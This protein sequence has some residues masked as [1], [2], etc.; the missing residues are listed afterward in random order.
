MAEQ[1][2][3]LPDSPLEMQGLLDAELGDVPKEKW[4]AALVEAIEV[5]EAE[6]ER[7][8]YPETEAF[9]LAQ[10]GIVALAQI[11][12][13]RYRYLPR[14]DDLVTA[15]RDAEIYRKARRGNID[16]LARA[17]GLTDRHVHRIVHQQHKLHIRK[18]Q[19]NLFEE[20]EQG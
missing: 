15:V 3:L 8:G 17:H 1:R 14:G 4:P 13:G 7:M 5:L 9:R 12:G 2:D 20:G 11:W 19:G 6:Y 18:R 16:A 10:R